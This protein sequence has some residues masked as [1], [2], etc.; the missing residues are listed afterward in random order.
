M[1]NGFGIHS[2]NLEIFESDSEGREEAVEILRSVYA[3]SESD[4]L[5]CG[6]C[7]DLARATLDAITEPWIDEEHKAVTKTAEEV[8]LGYDEL[9]LPVLLTKSVWSTCVEWTE[10]DTQ[11]QCYQDQDARLWDVV[12]T[13]GATLQKLSFIIHQRHEY[14]ILCIPRDGLS[15][16]SIEFRLKIQ[17]KELNNQTWLVIDFVG[18]STD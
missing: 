13:G 12:A 10:R 18:A 8:G 5:L 14:T 1:N 7:L 11:R 16:E 3:N 2:T 9:E 4:W 15:N 17:A 6:N